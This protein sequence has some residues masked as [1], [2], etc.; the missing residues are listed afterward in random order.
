[1]RRTALLI[2][3]RTGDLAGVAHDVEAMAG[4]LD[5]RGFTIARH[6]GAAATRAGIL[7]GYERL[8]RDA[9][10][11]DAAVVYYSGHGGL[12]RPPR[13]SRAPKLQFLAPTDYAESADGD[14]RGITAPELSVLLVR[15]TSATR[16]VTV[17]LDA[18][19]A[20]HMARGDLLVKALPAMPYLDVAEHLDRLRRQGLDTAVRD[21]LGN[22]HAVRVVACGRE[23]SAYEYTNPAGHRAGLLTDALVE[24][25]HAA[26]DRSVT[27]A[28][29]VAGVRD[30]VR[31]VMPFQRPDV[32]GPALRAMFEAAGVPLEPPPDGAALDAEVTIAWGRVA[33]GRLDPLPLAGAA[34]HAGDR[35]G[36]RVRNDG[37]ATVHV[38]LLAFD[39]LSRIA[40]VTALDPAG[41]A[42]APGEEH[43]IGRDELD[44]RLGGIPLDWPADAGPDPRPRPA[45]FAALV[46]PAPVAPAERYRDLSASASGAGRRDVHHIRF[47]LSPA[48]RAAPGAG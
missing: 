45:A 7:D 37:A 26:G 34:L 23:Q 41:V 27:W 6:E 14:F 32:E 31:A 30:R 10:P 29:L 20:A 44:D 19:H 17:I 3:A 28:E 24:A 16:N 18:C 2:G 46:T 4:A 22:P 43:V 48:P 11:Q 33:D 9:R 36:V 40:L 47:R 12:A 39:V 35:V 21:A 8:I 13:A 5:R 42:I 38:S 25:L 15:L 1:M